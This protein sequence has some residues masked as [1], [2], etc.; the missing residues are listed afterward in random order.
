MSS[1]EPK[2]TMSREEIISEYKA[3]VECLEQGHPIV[4]CQQRSANACDY[5]GSR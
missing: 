2:K 5:E 3:A 1:C 4:K